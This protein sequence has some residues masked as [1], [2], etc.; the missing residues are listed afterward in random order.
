MKDEDVVTTLFDRLPPSFGHLITALEIHPISELTL[1]FITVRLMHKVSKKKKRYYNC[2]KLG[3]IAYNCRSKCKV[4]ANITRLSDDFAF[5][6]RD[7]TSNTATSRYI[8]DSGA[9]QHMTP[10]K[11]FFDI[12]KSVSGHKIFMGDND[13]VEAA[14]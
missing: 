11:H 6:T 7:G 14:C 5:V 8:V 3:H 13:M 9:L 1:D 10:H 4:N 12:Y 2:G